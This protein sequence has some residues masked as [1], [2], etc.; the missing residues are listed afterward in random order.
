MDHRLLEIVACPV[1]KGKL[2]YD[3]EKNELICKFD[4]LA[5]PIQDGIPVL[6]EPEARTLSSDEV[7]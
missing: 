2:N 1:C 7:K 4:R 6:I 5:Y 3:K